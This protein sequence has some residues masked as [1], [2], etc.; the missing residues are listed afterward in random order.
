MTT[1]PAWAGNLYNWCV[2]YFIWYFGGV[3]YVENNF[4]RR[5]GTFDDTMGGETHVG[6]TFMKEGSDPGEHNEN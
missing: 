5:G 2:G 6:E 3:P 4:W 1:Y